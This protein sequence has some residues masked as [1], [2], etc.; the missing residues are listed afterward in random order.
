MRYHA[1]TSQT[2]DLLPA[3]FCVYLSKYVSVYARMSLSDRM[4]TADDCDEPLS[5]V[6]GE[7]G[8]RSRSLDEYELVSVES[9][10]TGEASRAQ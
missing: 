9:D 10:S 4:L 7:K 1:C 2:A 6:V 5:L 8:D 3:E